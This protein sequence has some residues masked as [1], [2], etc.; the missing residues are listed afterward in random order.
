MELLGHGIGPFVCST[1][2]SVLFKI[3]VRLLHPIRINAAFSPSSDYISAESGLNESLALFASKIGY[4][5]G[6]GGG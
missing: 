4:I 5:N 1:G 3:L 6:K 2:S